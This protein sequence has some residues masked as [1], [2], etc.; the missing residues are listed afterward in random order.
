MLGKAKGTLRRNAWRWGREIAMRA[1]GGPRVGNSSLSTVSV[2]TENGDKATEFGEK[3]DFAEQSQ[4]SG[5]SNFLNR[6]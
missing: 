3:A 2:A 4:S 5:G 1:L 6:E